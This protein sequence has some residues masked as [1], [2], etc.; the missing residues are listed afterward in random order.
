MD[1]Q[2]VPWVIFG[3]TARGSGARRMGTM[4]QCEDVVD[5]AAQPWKQT[6]HP[7][8]HAFRAPAAVFPNTLNK[9]PFHWQ[10][11]NE[12]THGDSVKSGP[13][14]RRAES[15]RRQ[16]WG[17]VEGMNQEWEGERQALR[18][19]VGSL[20]NDAAAAAAAVK[21]RNEKSFLMQWKDEAVSPLVR[22]GCFRRLVE[23]RFIISQ[24]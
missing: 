19:K 3:F 15:G 8:R 13:E 24:K 14:R 17:A 4:K 10:V 18:H 6:C 1:S 23:L 9:S 11:D 5:P 12:I 22:P 20:Y 16:R 21:D 7:E 2:G